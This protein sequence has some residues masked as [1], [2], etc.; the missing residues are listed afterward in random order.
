MYATLKE[1]QTAELLVEIQ[2]LEGSGVQSQT[3]TV[4]S[5]Q[6]QA[7]RTTNTKLHYQI[8]HLKEV[9]LLLFLQNP[10]F[11]LQYKYIIK[12]TVLIR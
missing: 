7:L 12:V 4:D 1:A 3:S 5:P 8:K 10:I 2:Q 11:L 9:R 6:L